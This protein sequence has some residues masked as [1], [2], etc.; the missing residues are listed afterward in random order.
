[1]AYDRNT[2][3]S[4]QKNKTMFYSVLKA[5]AGYESTKVKAKMLI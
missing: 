2:A 4:H 5:A 1:M 3:Q